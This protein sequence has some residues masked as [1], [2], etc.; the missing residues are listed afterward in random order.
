MRLFNLFSMKAHTI[1]FILLIIY[2]LSIYYKLS[3][4]LFLLT[5]ANKITM[6]YKEILLFMYGHNQYMQNHIN[7]YGVFQFLFLFESKVSAP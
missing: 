1:G 6:K 3:L 7:T 2:S 5:Q 4:S